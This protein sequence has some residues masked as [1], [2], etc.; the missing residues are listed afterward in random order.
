MKT[1]QKELF[2]AALDL[3]LVIFK[4][5]LALEDLEP[6]DPE[7]ER[8]ESIKKALATSRR[9]I[10]GVRLRLNRRKQTK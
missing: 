1:E 3:D 9:K 2:L 4:I 6:N 8:L 10:A 5:D 7:A